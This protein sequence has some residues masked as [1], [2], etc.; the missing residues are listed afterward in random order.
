M[1][2]CPACILLSAVAQ[3]LNVAARFSL[4][5]DLPSKL[6]E[7]ERQRRGLMPTF[8][9][10]SAASTPAAFCSCSSDLHAE[11]Y[12]RCNAADHSSAALLIR[13]QQPA[14]SCRYMAGS[15]DST[16]DLAEPCKSKCMLAGHC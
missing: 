13:E 14:T 3:V 7:L 9:L 8:S 6:A 2:L 10:A 1:G 12:V 5:T 4:T 16:T 11:L 15:E